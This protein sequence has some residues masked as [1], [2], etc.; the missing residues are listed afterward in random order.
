PEFTEKGEISMSFDIFVNFH[1]AGEF[2]LVPVAVLDRVFGPYAKP[3]ELGCWDLSYPGSSGVLYFSPMGND[4]I[5]GFSVN[6]PPGS[7]L[8][9]KGMLKILKE[10]PAVLY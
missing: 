1:R 6:R 3:R 5:D 8:F 7:H 2:E 4:E 10:T 9:W